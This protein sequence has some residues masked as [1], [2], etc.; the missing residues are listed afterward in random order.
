MEETCCIKSFFVNINNNK[1]NTY[2]AELQLFRQKSIRITQGKDK[3]NFELPDKFLTFFFIL[4]KPWRNI[5]IE[6]IFF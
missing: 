5:F 4:F 2:C 1:H 3:N 6:C